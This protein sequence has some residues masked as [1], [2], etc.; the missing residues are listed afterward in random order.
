MWFSE[1]SKLEQ[2]L[3]KI[4]SKK[5]ADFRRKLSSFLFRELELW[6]LRHS[7]RLRSQ[8][9]SITRVFR[10]FTMLL[11]KLIF[12]QFWGQKIK[13]SARISQCSISKS[14]FYAIQISYSGSASKT[15][16]NHICIGTFNWFFL[17]LKLWVTFTG[18]IAKKI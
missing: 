1:L 16:S 5:D 7:A 15:K 9:K 18:K 3:Q 17:L 6:I 2:P 10:D 8:F 14:I 11:K 12:P 13:N 4:S